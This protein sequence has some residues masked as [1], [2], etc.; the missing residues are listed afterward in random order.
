M[1]NDWQL[2]LL[3]YRILAFMLSLDRVLFEV[4]LPTFFS[5]P[6]AQSLYNAVKCF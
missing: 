4:V 3:N 2:L 1:T 5:S 6:Y